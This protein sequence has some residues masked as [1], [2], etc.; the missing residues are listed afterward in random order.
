[1]WEESN[2]KNLYEAS[3]L[4]LNSNKAK[5]RLGWKT[6]LNINETLEWT[7]S[8]YKEFLKNSNMKKYTEDQINRFVSL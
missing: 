7:I 2:G 4:K 1:M 5:K 8:W 3:I 6:K